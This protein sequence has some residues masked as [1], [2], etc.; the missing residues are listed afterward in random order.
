[1]KAFGFLVAV[2]LVSAGVLSAQ[3]ATTPR[4]EVG[5]SYSGVHLDGANN[6]TQITGNGGSGYVEYNFNRYL[7]AVA[8]FGAYANTRDGINETALTYLFGPRLN[9]RHSRF[10]PY[11]QALFGGAYAWNNL[12]SGTQNSF[13]FAVGG[14]LDVNLTKHFT[15]KPAQVEYVRSQFDSASLGGATSNF[16]DHQNGIRYSAG[17]VF[18]FGYK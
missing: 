14:G 6:N 17:V 9:W 12:N 18:Q 15:I 8:D 13:A 5:A 16:G 2:V 11:V 10:N 4:F 7:G 1:M 3:E